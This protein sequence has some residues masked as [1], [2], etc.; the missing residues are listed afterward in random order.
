MQNLWSR[1]TLLKANSARW[2]WTG[3]QGLIRDPAHPSLSG[4]ERE[5]HHVY[6]FSTH[7]KSVLPTYP[8]ATT[9]LLAAGN[10]GSVDTSI[11]VLGGGA[12]ERWSLTSVAGK[13]R[14][15]TQLVFGIYTADPC[16]SRVGGGGQ[17]F[18]L[19]SINPATE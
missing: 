5:D 1:F 15:L 19:D 3:A 17:L 2:V 8:D 4:R 11:R 12:E 9:T 10:K 14:R 18:Y 13:K 16:A 7:Q 6:Y